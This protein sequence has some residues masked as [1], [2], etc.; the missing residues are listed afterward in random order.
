MKKIKVLYHLPYSESLYADRFIGEGYRD[1][2]IDKGHLFKFLTVE[3]N[4][5]QLISEFKPNIFITSVYYYQQ[6]DLIKLSWVRKQGLKVFFNSPLPHQ[7]PF[8][9]ELKSVVKNRGFGD[10]YFGAFDENSGNQLCDLLGIAYHHVPLAANKKY[11]F[12][13]ASVKKYEC[14]IIFMGANLPD[15][16][17]TF[18]EWLFPLFKKNYNIKLF[19]R[20]WTKLDILKRKISSLS[21]KLR[22]PWLRNLRNFV[23]PLEEENQLYSS[24]KISINI[25][26]LRQQREGID[27]NERTFKVPACGGFEICDPVLIVRRYFNKDEVVVARN[28]KEWFQLIDYYLNHDSERKVIQAKGTARA[29]R[30]HTYHNRVDQLLG[31]YHSL[32]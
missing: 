18:Q 14:D 25:H 27:V 24:A 6:I 26:D 13:T 7:L 16:R 8:T 31:I 1:A 20:D 11:H 9:D 23:I 2:F 28:P 10:A 30:D 17:E 12:P 22:L 19:G 32:K 5:S 4:F 15:K 29:L 21:Q 3:D